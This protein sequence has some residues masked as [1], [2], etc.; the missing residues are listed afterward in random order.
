VLYAARLYRAGKAPLILAS[1]GKLPWLQGGGEAIIIKD[2][3]VEWGVP[4]KAVLTETSSRTTREN[5]L[6]IRELLERHGFQRILLVTSAM[7]MPR[8]MATFSNLDIAVIPAT[9]D[10]TVV[11][12]LNGNILDWLP[13][14]GALQLSSMA[15]KEYLGIWVYRLRGW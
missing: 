12:K 1:G 8:A 14:A 6:Y 13:T 2:L 3:L 4:T 10:I 11:D 15:I 5:A 7:H 9:T